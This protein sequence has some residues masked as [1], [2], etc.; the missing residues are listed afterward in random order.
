MKIRFNVKGMTCAACQSHV[1]SS[2]ERLKGVNIVN[3]SLIQNVMDVEFNESQC[4]IENIIDAVKSAGYTASIPTKKE[5]KKDPKNNDVILLI[6]T[7]SI[8]LLLMYISMGHMINLPIPSF[9]KDVNNSFYFA[10]IQ[11]ILTLPIVIIYRRYFISGYKKLF[12]LKPN[13]DSLVALSAT[14]SIIYGIVTMI[15]ML[16]GLKNNDLELVESYRHSLYFESAAMILVMISFGK[17]LEDKSKKKTTKSLESL[18][19]LAPKKALLFKD[20]E[21]IEVLAE[22]IKEG[23][24]VIVKRGDII[25][26]DGR[27]IFGDAT[28]DQSNITGESFPVSKAL[29]DEVFASTIVTSGYL[30][31]ESLKVNQDTSIASIIRLVEEASNSKAPI[32]KLADRIAGYFVPIV[33]LISIISFSL[34]MIF[35]YGFETSFNFGI[36]VLVIACPCALGLATPVAIMVGTGKGAENGLLIK[37]AEI[38][39]KIQYIKTIVLD[40]TGTLTKGKMSVNEIISYDENILPFSYSLERLSEHPLA[41]AIVNKGLQEKCKVYDVINY[42]SIDGIGIQGEINNQKILI[43]NKKVLD[44]FNIKNNE[45]S[46]LMDEY[47]KKG[48]IPLV[49]ANE[50]KILG[51]IVISDELKE[52]SIE[53]VSELKKMGLRIIMLTGDNKNTAEY[54]ASLTGIEEVYSNVLPIEKEKIIKELQRDKHH[55]VAMVGD[56]VNDALALVSSDLSIA[57]GGGSEMALQTS[58]VVLLKKDLLGIK[59]VILLS[60]RIFNTIKLNLFWAFFYNSIGIVLASGLLYPAFKISLNPMIGAIAMSLSSVFVVMNALTIN[61]FKIDKREIEVIKGENEMK[62]IIINVRGM[63]CPKCKAHVE[64]ALL[65][66]NGVKE[67]EASLDQNNATITCDDHVKVSDLINIVNE[68]GYEAFE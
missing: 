36:S 34:F 55:L 46:S 4:S 3:V 27:I 22:D 2:V 35:Q 30:K 45:V 60:K 15:L 39:E 5:V 64:K 9:L 47:A 48:Q 10:L 56:G 40:K 26:V 44:Y 23:D 11:L 17:F 61:L 54:I 31:V 7:F 68:E 28:I 67:V 32:S 43:G 42:L 33:L 14:A 16:F 25:P 13:M 18:I 65:S 24:I 63:M 52:T 41:E 19:N 49:V 51:V 66:I 50:T 59:N 8:L 20:N 1:H 38:L 57:V 62:K 58:D 29:N 6:I 12:H 37:N 53:A 21:E